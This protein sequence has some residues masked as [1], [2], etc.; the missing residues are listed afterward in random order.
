M[1]GDP[2]EIVLLTQSERLL[3]EATTINK[4][5]DI[6]DKAQAAMAYAKKVGLSKDII[7]HAAAIKVQAER[8]LGKMLSGIDL[9][10]SA[11]G[12]QYTG[13]AVRSQGAT[14]PIRLQ[15]LGIT[16]SDS[17]RAQQIAGLPTA[18]FNGYV[19]Q[20]VQSGREPTTAGLLRLAKQQK[21]NGTVVS[22][23]DLPA[24]Y[25][26]D[27]R[28]LIA[29]GRRFATILADPP[30]RFNNQATRAATDNFYPTMTVE[31]IAAEPFAQLAADNC[32]LHLWVPHSFLPAAFTVMQVWGFSYKSIFTWVKP[33]YGLG[34]YWRSAVEFMLLGV[35]G[36]LPFRDSS[37]RN[38]IE[39][40]TTEHSVK[41]EEIRTLIEKVSPPPYLELYGRV[42]PPNPGWTTYG[43][44]IIS[45]SGRHAS[46]KGTSLSAQPVS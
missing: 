44:Q 18:T 11:P 13:K 42:I 10:N 33:H 34:N 40:D 19:K 14:G 39:L 1:N 6:R 8:R 22:N 9:A 20:S 4:V 26:N 3:A 35:R 5:M 37:Q 30:W 7:L 15:D 25:F 23:S 38:W 12:N 21:A 32:H 27:L 2:R 24:G 46:P 36:R 41:P 29:T 43:N 28:K 45:P 31:Q 17:S 16:K